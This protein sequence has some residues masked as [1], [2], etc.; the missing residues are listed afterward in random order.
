MQTSMEYPKKIENR[1]IIGSSIY[2]KEWESRSQSNINTLMFI[3]N[4]Q[5]VETS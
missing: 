5:D 4:S 1:T 2:P 3:H